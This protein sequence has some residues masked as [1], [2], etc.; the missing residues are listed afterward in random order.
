MIEDLHKKAIHDLV[1][2][3]HYS[4]QLLEWAYDPEMLGT[5]PNNALL[6]GVLVEVC[7][8]LNTLE[9]LLS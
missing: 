5:V 1:K 8:R 4:S 7:E 6:A 2:V 9:A 3:K